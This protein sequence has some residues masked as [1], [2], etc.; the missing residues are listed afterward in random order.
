[1]QIIVEASFT[2]FLKCLEERGG[3]PGTEILSVLKHKEAMQN[4]SFMKNTWKFRIQE[5]T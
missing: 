1:M 4:V 5:V 3:Q 2:F